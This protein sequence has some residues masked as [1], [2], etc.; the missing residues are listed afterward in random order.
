MKIVYYTHPFLLDCDL[1]LIREMQR[2][3]HEVMM[4]I[5]LAPFSLR[6]SLL[7]I[8]KQIKKDAI[9]P[10][11]MYSEMNNY[12]QY[13][14]LQNIFFIN[15]TKASTLTLTYCHL[16]LQM[17]KMIRHFNPDIIHVTYPLDSLEMLLLQ[18]RSRILLVM[19][20]PFPHSGKKNLRSS[21]SR[22][23][24]I[25]LIPKIVLLN[26]TQK[27][28][29]SSYY[30][31]PARK[32]FINKLGPYN[33]IQNFKPTTI[34]NNRNTKILFFGLISPYK[35]LE[36]L[37]KAMI[38][39]HEICPSVELIIAGSGKIYFDFTPYEKLNYIKV[40]NHYIDMQEL[41]T[42]LYES[43][44]VICPYKDATQSGVIMTSFAMERPIIAS[45]VG[46][47]KEQI[48]NEKTG[49][50][51]PPCDSEALADAIIKL[52]TNPQ[53]VDSMKLNIKNLNTIGYNNWNTI[54]NKYL[55]YY[56]R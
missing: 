43:S 50:L 33:C 39:V 1:P 21:I 51:I 37:C 45:N 23:I 44:F 29:F 49:L 54:S 30:K 42:F 22:Y 36:Y 41:A 32:L 27:K 52:A 17:C 8:K 2:K 31:I 35:G 25:K 10:A 28:E 53:L 40:H 7:N 14:N 3:G 18:F 4:F 38:K 12:S 34:T 48:E 16:I 26:K 5:S 24:S 11:S 55:E 13:I 56:A 19:H 46:S 6:G 20:D 9:I 47:L 15:R